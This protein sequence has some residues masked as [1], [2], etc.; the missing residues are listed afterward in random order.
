MDE[1]TRL[2]L[3]PWLASIAVVAGLL[4]FVPTDGSGQVACNASLTGTLPLPEIRIS[5]A[6][7]PLRVSP[8]PDAKTIV[9]LPPDIE[10]ALLDE[11]D[12]W[13]VVGYRD[14]DRNRRLY[15]A[16]QDAEGPAAASLE[17][18]QV[19]AQ[20]WAAAHTLACERV[21]GERRAVRS[22]AA[23]AVIAGLTSIIWHVYIDDDDYFGTGFAVWSGIS[24]GSLVGAV[25]KAFGLSRA[26]RAL[27]DLGSP[28]SASAGTQQR[29]VGL[30]ADL[31]FDTGMKRLAL[32]AT[33]HPGTNY[34]K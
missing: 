26:R 22:L 25:Y 4:A 33:W 9:S 7:A 21:A 29:L 24:V 2:Q 13:Y 19:R 34:P 20:E 16:V 14:G 3:F 18:R 17:P 30:G 10:V 5:A 23:A 27:R 31:R 32:V 12:G 11:S 28:S 8:R 6:K 1:S 15:V